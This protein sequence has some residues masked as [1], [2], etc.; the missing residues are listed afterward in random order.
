[1]NS[2]SF[3]SLDQFGFENVRGR[4]TIRHK[5][6]AVEALYFVGIR[7]SP[8]PY[9]CS[10]YLLSPPR[11]DGKHSTRK[12]VLPIWQQVRAAMLA[13]SPRSIEVYLVFLNV[14]WRTTFLLALKTARTILLRFAEAFTTLVEREH[15]KYYGAVYFHMQILIL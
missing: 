13:N 8:S 1:M 10:I 15:A 5:A 6:E 7:L 11:L 3:I 2:S 4:S 9:S 12:L 14:R